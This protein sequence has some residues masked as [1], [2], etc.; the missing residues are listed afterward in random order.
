VAAQRILVIGCSGAGKSTLA[1]VIAERHRLPLIHLDR[2][3][4]RPGWKAPSETEWAADIERLI[5]EP[6]WVMDGNFSSTM[7]RR[8]ERA[9]AIVFLDLPRWLCLL[10]VLRRVI[11]GYGRSRDD[12]APGCPERFDW[13]FLKWIWNYPIRSRP[14]TLKLLRGYS[15]IAVVLR[16]PGAA[17]AWIEA[18]C[19]LERAS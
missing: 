19:R 14:K 10:R 1:K 13:G 16:S 9:E 2:C 15:G 7:P 18:G 3:Y 8:A 11:T 12:V 6:A 4:W 17:R 5:A